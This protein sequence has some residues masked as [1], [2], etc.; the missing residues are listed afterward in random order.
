MVICSVFRS[1]IEYYK[2]FSQPC[3]VET[4]TKKSPFASRWFLLLLLFMA[5]GKQLSG[6]LPPPTP[7][8]YK[9]NK[10]NSLNWKPNAPEVNSPP[11]G[12][13]DVELWTIRSF[14]FRYGSVLRRSVQGS[15]VAAGRRS[16]EQNEEDQRGGAEAPGRRAGGRREEPGRERDTGRHDGQ[17]RV[18]D[19][20]RKQGDWTW[21]RR[22]P[23]C[24]CRFLC[25]RRPRG[26]YDEVT[27]ASALN[28]LTR[29]SA[30]L[31]KR[32]GV[33][34]WHRRCSPA[35]PGC[36][37]HIDRSNIH[38]CIRCHLFFFS[39]QCAVHLVRLLCQ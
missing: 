26:R 39:A 12:W 10:S 24:G 6:A 21:C 25:D 11:S 33:Y 31:R 3:V 30:D 9:L 15:E 14:C 36:H 22:G 16:A 8:E 13:C 5:V 2:V 27:T 18:P 20:D 34:T 32:H 35:Q 28:Y 1:H 4:S 37:G 19:P 17:S 23:A 29:C 38:R 7:L